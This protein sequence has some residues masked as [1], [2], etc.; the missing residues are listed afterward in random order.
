MSEIV[1]EI[2]SEGSSHERPECGRERGTTETRSDPQ[3]RDA[4]ETELEMV[5]RELELRTRLTT[6]RRRRRDPNATSAVSVNTLRP[7]ALNNRELRAL[8]MREVLVRH[9]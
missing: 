5:R 9:T 3:P 7:N 4:H 1:V 6:V 8:S 2:A